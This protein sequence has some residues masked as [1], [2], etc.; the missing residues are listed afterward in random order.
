MEQYENIEP[1]GLIAPHAGYVYSGQVAAYAYSLLHEN[2]FDT[3]ILL[4]SSHRY[5]ENTI[6]VY[7]GD[8]YET[9]LGK[10]EIDKEIATKIMEKHHHI[11][12]HEY[13][14]QVEH[15]LEAQIPFL[16]YQLKKFQIVPI[17]TSTRNSELLSLLAESMIEIIQKTTKKVLLVCSTDMSH[18]HS[19]E[20]AKKMDEQTIKLLLD[21]NW[22]GLAEAIRSGESELCGYY[23]LLPFLKTLKAFNSDT[24]ELLYYANSGD[25]TNDL[26]AEQVV[27]YMSMVFAKK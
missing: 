10:I 16:Q 3:V 26:N 21:K 12:F 20:V 8:V 14:H 4:G 25:A 6:S 13:I 24:G 22:S 19:Y 15:S 27:G 7:N 5:L 1:F 23:A 17:L 2:Q 9:P 11:G 18:Y